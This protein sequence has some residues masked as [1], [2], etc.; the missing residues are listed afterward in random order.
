MIGIIDSAINVANVG[1]TG[2]RGLTGP[3]GLTGL[4]GAD[5]T[6]QGPQGIQ[7][8]TGA[9]STVQGPQGDQGIQGDQGDQG[10]DSVVVGPTGPIGADSKTVDF[11]ASGTLPD[12]IPVI[13]N[14]DGTVEAVAEV[15]QFETIPAGAIYSEDTGAAVLRN[16][17]TF[18]VNNP[19]R[20]IISRSTGLVVGTVAGT[21]ITFGAET[22]VSLL[23]VPEIIS[24]P[25]VPD[26]FILLYHD[27]Y[28]PLMRVLTVTGTSISVSEYINLNI[29]A[30]G[31]SYG[32][33]AADPHNVGQFIMV[34]L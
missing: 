2:L 23:V 34:L 28:T 13:L 20:F 7:G 22:I 4:T 14:S 32:S 31:F 12:G 24:L 33:L 25:G 11:V 17:V 19:G 21:T 10:A 5:S 16:A 6:V 30:G 1:P 27:G 3:I 8:E 18:D 9:D 29:L 26:K 15:G